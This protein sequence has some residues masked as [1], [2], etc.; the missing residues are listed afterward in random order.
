MSALKP[1]RRSRGFTLLELLI[2]ITIFAVVAALA[3][4]G[5]ATVLRARQE[6]S[7]SALQLRALQ[8]AVFLIERDT[9]QLVVRPIRDEYGDRQPALYGGDGRIEFTRGGW[10]NP[11]GQVRSELQR[12]AYLVRDHQLIRDSWQVLDRAP[13][14][15]PYEAPLLDDVTDLQLRFLDEKNEW[16]DSWPP[17]DRSTTSPAATVPPPR[18]AEITL[19]TAR[20][21]TITRLIRLPG[22]T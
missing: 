1:Y 17:L 16:T 13:D 15:V 18:A 3:Y 7:A 8:Q 12:V 21:G 11:A 14:S 6:T 20:W 19:V 4:G 2:A 22:A 5:L 9:T 10:A